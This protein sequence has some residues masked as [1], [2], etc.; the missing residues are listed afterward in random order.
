MK[1]KLKQFLKKAWENKWRIIPWVISII[2]SSV[3][4]VLFGKLKK[5]EGVVSNLRDLNTGLQ[6]TVER[7]TYIIGKQNQKLYGK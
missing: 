7:Q 4:A 5:Q 6:K 2:L 1:K 3:C